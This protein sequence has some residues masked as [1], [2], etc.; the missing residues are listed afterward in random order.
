MAGPN[1]PTIITPAIKPDIRGYPPTR[2][3]P[4][5]MP[6]TTPPKVK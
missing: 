2:N 5:P 6:A 4:P 1:G 3:P